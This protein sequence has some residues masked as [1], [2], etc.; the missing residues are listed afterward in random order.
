MG[1]YVS[2]TKATEDE[3]SF[4]FRCSHSF[5]TRFFLGLALYSI[6]FP[7]FYFFFFGGKDDVLFKNA[8][9]RNFQSLNLSSAVQ[10]Y[11]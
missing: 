2:W 5:V 1:V 11:S 6:L 10:Y 7:Y 8:V 3:E 9:E 4:L